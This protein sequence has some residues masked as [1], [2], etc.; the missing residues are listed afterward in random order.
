MDGVEPYPPLFSILMHFHIQMKKYTP[1]TLSA[2]CI[3]FFLLI[4][5]EQHLC[6]ASETAANKMY[7]VYMGGRKHSD[8][9]LVVDSHHNVLATVLGTSKETAAD[10]IIYHYKHGFSGFATRLTDSQAKMMAE[11]PG[12]IDVIPKMVHKLHTT[13]SWDYLGLSFSHAT[14]NP[15]PKS[16]MGDGIIVGVIDTGSI[17]IYRLQGDRIQRL[18]MSWGFY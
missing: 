16:N 3:L 18:G 9:S 15:Y 11:M 4:S 6:T 7:I 14:N 8:P 2:Q 13:R 10:S 12:V 5:Y 1:I 17:P